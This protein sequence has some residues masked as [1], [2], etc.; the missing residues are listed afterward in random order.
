MFVN[1]LRKQKVLFAAADAA[2]LVLALRA[3]LAIHDP[4]GTMQD[5]LAANPA[6]LVLIGSAVLGAWIL[7]F[8]SLD[9]YRMRGG[10]LAEA[11][12]I[13]RG[14]ALGALLAITVG[15]LMHLEISRI[16]ML[17]AYPLAVASGAERPRA[18]ALRDPPS[19]RAQ[20]SLGSAGDRRAEPGRPLPL[21]PGARRVEPLRTG[22]LR[23]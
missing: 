13:C 1:E 5:R 3:A 7:I 19:V 20:G 11:L 21:R 12:A 2:A 23:R 6:A 17:L 15:F 8:R 14:N 9:L 16:T 10:S 4:S 18:A 22:G